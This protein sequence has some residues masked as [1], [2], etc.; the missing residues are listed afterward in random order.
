MH[1]LQ[2]KQPYLYMLVVEW[3]GQFLR[4]EGVNRQTGQLRRTEL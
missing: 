1:F 4:Q 3:V 2:Q